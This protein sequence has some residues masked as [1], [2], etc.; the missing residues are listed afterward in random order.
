MLEKIID[1][2]CFKSYMEILKITEDFHNTHVQQLSH[3]THWAHAKKP[4]R[5]VKAS[6]ITNIAQNG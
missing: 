1:F 3:I 4:G 5:I 6:P 2:P